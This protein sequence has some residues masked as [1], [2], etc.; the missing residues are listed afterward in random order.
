MSVLMEVDAVSL[1]CFLLRRNELPFSIDLWSDPELPYVVSHQ[2]SFFHGHLLDP[3]HIGPVEPFRELTVVVH[4][5]PSS[6]T[7]FVP[8][9]WSA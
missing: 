4:V 2:R 3:A 6:Y 7:K 1:A 9:A 8:W 5:G